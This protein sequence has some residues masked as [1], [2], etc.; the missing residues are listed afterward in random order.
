MELSINNFEG[1]RLKCVPLR[2]EFDFWNE[3]FGSLAKEVKQE[4]RSIHDS[5]NLPNWNI[6]L[7]FTFFYINN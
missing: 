4:T 7:I 5:I 1:K 6:L 3:Y 2:N